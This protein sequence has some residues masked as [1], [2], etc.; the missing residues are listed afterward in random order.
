MRLTSEEAKQM[1]FSVE[2]AKTRL[3]VEKV[4]EYRI[5]ET[6]ANVSVD[7]TSN[8][9]IF[10]AKFDS[11]SLESDQFKNSSFFRDRIIFTVFIEI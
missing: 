10:I 7:L 6:A 5:G 4:I 11:K 9:T 2:N 3:S 1:S 8:F